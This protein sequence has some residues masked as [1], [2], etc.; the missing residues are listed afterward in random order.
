MNFANNVIIRDASGIFRSKREVIDLASEGA[1]EIE[2]GEEE[3]EDDVCA[4]HIWLQTTFLT[5]ESDDED[6]EDVA[7][8]GNL[9]DD[10]Q[11]ANQQLKIQT[12]MLV[13]YKDKVKLW[14]ENGE[15]NNVRGCANGRSSFFTKQR[16][17]KEARIEAATIHDI[18]SY[19]NVGEVRAHMQ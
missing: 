5:D 9:F 8:M 2:G 17:E 4:Q 19:Y 7:E 12:N 3:G 14:K 13:Q 10:L 15:A 1:M 18:R 16:K 6:D 11:L